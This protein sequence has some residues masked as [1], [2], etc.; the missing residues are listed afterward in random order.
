MN[1]EI[2]QVTKHH[3]LKHTNTN[4]DTLTHHHTT[5]SIMFT[6]PHN[7]ADAAPL[8]TDWLAAT[9]AAK[10]VHDAYTKSDCLRLIF[11]HGSMHVIAKVPVQSLRCSYQGFDYS[12][13]AMIRM[14]SLNRNITQ[15]EMSSIR[16]TCH[17]PT[18]VLG[19]HLT[20]DTISSS[21]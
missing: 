21:K 3:T 17:D 10:A 12:Y 1:S 13:V 14:I 16:S 9:E 15:Q 4:N 5:V 6:M 18:C 19:L 7:K 2:C 11:H 8:I 20:S